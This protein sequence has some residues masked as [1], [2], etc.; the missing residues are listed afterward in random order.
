MDGDGLPGSGIAV[1]AEVDAEQKRA[2]RNCKE[3]LHAHNKALKDLAVSVSA[4]ARSMSRVATS[5]ELLSRDTRHTGTIAVASSL[6][7]CMAGAT[8]SEEM[9]QLQEEVS[10]S[11]ERRF[12][13]LMREHHALE[14][15]RKRRA[16]ALKVVEDI[17]H[18]CER[19]AASRDSGPQSMAKYVAR[20]TERDAQELEHRRLSSEFDDAYDDF[21]SQLATL[22]HEDLTEVTECVHR[23]LSILSYQF[24]KSNEYLRKSAPVSPFKGMGT[25]SD[26]RCNAL[27]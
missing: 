22:V 10:Y 19:L 16:K 13:G 20:V 6:S 11:L 17:R 25:G 3:A 27:P 24:R 26:G 18:Q 9:E 14:E 5:F 21:F 15:R 8:E 23:A 4:C 12:K 2:L 7:R 1:S